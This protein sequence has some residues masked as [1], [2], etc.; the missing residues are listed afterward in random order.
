MKLRVLLRRPMEAW[1]KGLLS[2]SILALVLQVCSVIRAPRWYQYDFRAYYYAPRILLNSGDPYSYKTLAELAAQDGLAA[3][4]HPFL[5]PPHSL[6]VFLPLA[7]LQFFEAYYCWLAVKLAA[8]GVFVFLACRLLGVPLVPLAILVAFGLNGT[9]PADLRSGQVGLFE[10]TMVIAAFS[11]YING[12]LVQF[13]GTI[14][15]ASCFKLYYLCLLALLPFSCRRRKWLLL[16]LCVLL[17]TLA[18]WAESSLVPHMWGR[19]GSGA[20]AAIGSESIQ[21]GSLFNVLQSLFR[22][23]LGQAGRSYAWAAYWVCFVV[24]TVLSGTAMTKARHC[25]RSGQIEICLL[26]SLALI[27]VVPRLLVYQWIVALPAVSYYSAKAK[28]KLAVVVLL[29]MSLFPSLYVF[30]YLFHHPIEHRAE[31]IAAAVGSSTSVLAICIA[32]II[33]V[34]SAWGLSSDQNNR[35]VL[36]ESKERPSLA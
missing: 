28:S 15:A 33:S 8:L 27:L 32:W 1:H 9:V 23:G 12:K 35:R 5:Y 31:S 19:F 3:N 13:A 17:S 30:R 7:A 20:R 21:N 18:L 4:V 14:F 10:A 22:I 26:S 24:V 16:S 34:V 29:F 36:L 11:M 25:G 2:I 6:L